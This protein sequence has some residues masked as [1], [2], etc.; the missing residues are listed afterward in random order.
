M[1]LKFPVANMSELTKMEAGIGFTSGILV[2]AFSSFV[3]IMFFTDWQW[4]FKVFS[5]IGSIGIIGSI[6]MALSE[7]IKM[8]R[9]Y[10]EAVKEMEKMSK[11][12][13][14]GD[15]DRTKTLNEDYHH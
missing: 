5:A 1:K 13:E 3:L 8:R 9:T 15:G 10:L 4:Y 6:Y 12:E 11:P 2:G 7:Q 14:S